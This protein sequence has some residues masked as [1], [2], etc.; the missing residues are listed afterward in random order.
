[1]SKYCL[2][3]TLNYL[4]PAINNHRHRGKM[5]FNLHYT[6]SPNQC[7]ED[8]TLRGVKT[9]KR[10]KQVI[11]QQVQRIQRER[12]RE[13]RGGAGEPHNELTLAV[14]VVGFRRCCS[15]AC[16]GTAAAPGPHDLFHRAELRDD[17]PT[18]QTR[19]CSLF[20][21]LILLRNNNNIQEVH[22]GGHFLHLLS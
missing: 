6:P 21:W 1:M 10:A 19:C 9:L 15:V 11:R 7:N 20:L 14:V 18:G 16:R 8:T 13:K 5:V 12:E 17:P 22:A 2:Q 4:P 3:N